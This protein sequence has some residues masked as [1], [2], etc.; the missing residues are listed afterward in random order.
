MSVLAGMLARAPSVLILDEPLA[1]LDAASQQ[2]LLRVLEDLRRRA[3]LTVVVI[4]H[5]FAGLENLCPRTIELS[6]G[7]LQPVPA[8]SGSVS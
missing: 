6:D 3:G 7:A 8:S 5:D 1:G 2:G 4:S